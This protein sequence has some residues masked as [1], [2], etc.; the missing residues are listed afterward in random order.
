MVEK[1]TIAAVIVFAIIAISVA[2]VNSQLSD[3]NLV[4][5]FDVDYPTFIS[6]SST[7]LE[8][9]GNENGA[10]P[11]RSFTIYSLLDSPVK[12]E[13]HENELYDNNTGAIISE[14]R[15]IIDKTGVFSVSNSQ[16]EKINLDIDSQNVDAG[17]YFG[18]IIV[19]ATSE[20]GT[21][22]VSKVDVTATIKALPDTSLLSFQNIA[23]LAIFVLSGFGWIYREKWAQIEVKGYKIFVSKPYLV[24]IIALVVSYI[25]VYVLISEVFVDFYEAVATFAIAPYLTYT[26]AYLTEKRAQRI[27]KEKTSLT[28]RNEGLKE[29][30]NLIRDILGELTTH[31]ASFTP[32]YYLDNPADPRTKNAKLL[33]S[34]GNGKLSRAVWDKST[35]QGMIANITVLEIEKYYEF[36]ELHNQY[37]SCARFISDNMS[38]ETFEEIIDTPFFAKFGEFREKYGKLENVLFLNLSYYLGLFNKTN[39]APLNMEYPRFTRTL[40]KALVDYEIIDADKGIPKIKADDEETKF[41]DRFKKAYSKKFVEVTLR[42]LFGADQN[43]TTNDFTKWK[44]EHKKKEEA[45]QRGLASVTDEDKFRKEFEEYYTKQFLDAELRKLYN[46]D[47]NKTITDFT[48]WKKD[49]RQKEEAKRRIQEFRINASDLQKILGEIY[50]KDNI[51]EFYCVVEAD[52]QEKYLALRDS[53]K[54]LVEEAPLPKIFAEKE[55]IAAFTKNN[56]D[57]ADLLSEIK[58]FHPNTTNKKLDITPSPKKELEDIYLSLVQGNRKLL[59]NIKEFEGE[60]AKL[61][62]QYDSGN[63]TKEEYQKL[64]AE[65]LKAMVFDKLDLA[66]NP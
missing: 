48:E 1:K 43:R 62:K 36:I 66:S 29:D 10:L 60:L 53:I 64:K 52:F 8:F 50:S 61:K 16:P 14:E 21:T 40:L 55:K 6:L 27:D 26:A 38:K 65:N 47:T 30:I 35:K 54:N 45:K 32:D 63:I 3:S 41:K 7:K 13:M 44:E 12:V 49:H 11:S 22:T 24:I 9:I 25:W 58:N 23:I 18:T 56:K 42:K 20:N 46:E 19:T 51:P 31:F 39:L 2:A 15:V 37:Y 17:V 5:V 59:R 57:R 4:A 34:E 28:V 33:F